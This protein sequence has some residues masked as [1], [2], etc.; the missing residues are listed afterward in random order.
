VRWWLTLVAA[1]LAAFGLARPAAA[2]GDWWNCEVHWKVESAW[3]ECGGLALLRP[4][5]DSRVNLFLLVS[6]RRAG[7]PSG[8]GYASLRRENRSIGHVFAG[9][10]EVKAQF[11]PPGAWGEYFTFSSIAPG[12]CARL[13]QVR[14]EFYAALD[15]NRS[16]PDGERTLLKQ[17]RLQLER[18]CQNP[19][20]DE[21]SRPGSDL[22]TPASWPDGI[23]SPAGKAF[24]G[25]LKAAEAY[26]REDWKSARWQFAALAHSTEPWVAETSQ[27]LAIPGELDTVYRDIMGPYGYPTGSTTDLGAVERAAQAIAIYQSRYPQGRYYASAENSKRRIMGVTQDWAGFAKSISRLI[28][29]GA[30]DGAS[31]V[32]L[33]DEADPYLMGQDKA[34]LAG[35]QDSLLLA[36][37]DLRAMRIAP[38][39]RADDDYERDTYDLVDQPD[40]PDQ[41]MKF[42]RTDLE[43]QR[44]LF[45]GRKDLYDFLD[46]TFAFYHETDFQRVLAL[47]PAAKAKSYSSLE[48]SRQAL[49]AMALDRLGNSQAAQAWTGLLDGA[50]APYQREAIELGLTLSLE[51]TGRLDRVF[52]A[53]SPVR[54]TILRSRALQFTASPAMLRKAARDRS[55]PARERDTAAFTL[56]Y[57]DLRYGNYAR[58]AADRAVVRPGAPNETW[59]HNLAIQEQ[60]PAGLFVKGP[61]ARGGFACPDLGVTA[62]QLAAN[63]DN[64]HALLCLGEFWRLGGF[65]QYLPENLQPAPGDLGGIK[66]QYQGTPLERGDIYLQVL[67]NKTTP[68]SDRAY[69]LYRAIWCYSSDVGSGGGRRVE[70][71][72]RRAWFVELK[73]RFKDTVWAKRAEIYW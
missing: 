40:A 64:P 73:T 17:A 54:D 24:L 55:R 1:C 37:W 36:A 45:A 34:V 2:S 31:T 23:T 3:R 67:A 49:R 63:P 62:R 48:I 66:P 39:P 56:L 14:A 30:R 42:T 12:A 19:P 15:A 27:Y 4:G 43:E 46:A 22:T 18:G 47:I 11:F 32:E 60:V 8:F 9:W 20:Q 29:S 10:A 41:R 69:A 7:L 68:R 57:K 35:L 13:A 71:E 70:P 53:N 38:K 16:L 59:F 6:D 28:D 5:N 58:F 65:D 33:I 51:R 72:L 61:F 52:A 50:N 44:G 26:Y 25:Y 21:W